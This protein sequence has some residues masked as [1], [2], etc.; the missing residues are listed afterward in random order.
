GG[1][2]PCEPSHLHSRLYS[3]NVR[4]GLEL[5]PA[6]HE[7]N[8]RST[9]QT[10]QARYV[11][12]THSLCTAGALAYTHASHCQCSSPWPP[13]GNCRATFEAATPTCCAASGRRYWE[14]A[15]NHEQD[16]LV[17]RH[18]PSVGLPAVQP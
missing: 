6:L 11:R 4:Q 8:S 18:W 17:P 5:H 13:E 14:G 7:R 2:E 1:Q 12:Q 10:L 15:P 9:N 16:G 3:P